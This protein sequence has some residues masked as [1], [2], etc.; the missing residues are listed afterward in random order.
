VGVPTLSSKVSHLPAV[1]AEKVTQG[2]L[3]WWP[4]GSLLQLWGRSTVELLLSCLLELSWLELWMIVIV[5]LL[6]RSA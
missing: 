3:L 4:D 5:L 6:L 2:K 1:V